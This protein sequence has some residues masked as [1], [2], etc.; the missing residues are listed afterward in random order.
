[1]EIEI[2]PEADDAPLIQAERPSIDGEGQV[3]PVGQVGQL[4]D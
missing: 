2:A 4:G 3:K 1:M